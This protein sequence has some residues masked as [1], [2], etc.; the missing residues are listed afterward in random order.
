MGC[1]IN[2]CFNGAMYHVSA[3]N[4]IYIVSLVY[5]TMTVLNVNCDL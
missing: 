4:V 3:S 5:V 2:F 1:M